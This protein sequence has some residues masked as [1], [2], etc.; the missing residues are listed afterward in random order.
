MLAAPWSIDRGG[1]FARCAALDV[2]GLRH[3]FGLRRHHAEHAAWSAYGSECR[4][5]QV[6]GSTVVRATE[7]GP[8]GVEADAIWERAERL[9]DR[10]LAVRTADCVPILLATRD[11]EIVS[12]VHAGWRGTASRI[13]ARTVE[14]LTG[15][16]RA[17]EELIAAIGPSIGPCCYP[18]APDVADR[19]ARA[20][21]LDLEASGLDLKA[22][23]RAQLLAA[24]VPSAA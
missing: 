6:H 22:A 15:Q 12:A 17:A 18:V 5:R 24:G 23:N 11:G 8:E 19:V 10:H 21:G 2:G 7:I 3:A 16:G 9:E 14:T 20:S 1:S 13:V 4:I